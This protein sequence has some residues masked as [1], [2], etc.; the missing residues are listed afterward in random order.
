MS[1]PTQTIINRMSL[2]MTI[3]EDIVKA[4]KENNFSPKMV[5][6]L[7]RIH[8]QQ[9]EMEKAINELRSTQLEIA[10]SIDSIAGV[11]TGLMEQ[12]SD[13]SNHVGFDPAEMINS[14]EVGQ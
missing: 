1:D 13:V 7:L 3:P 12:I 6:T 11:A 10:K 14:E 9:I 4:C 8:N 5:E 2:V